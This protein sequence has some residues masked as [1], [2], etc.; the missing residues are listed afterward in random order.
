MKRPSISDQ[1]KSVIASGGKGKEVRSSA[2]RNDDPKAS[3]DDDERDITVRHEA[4]TNEE[5]RIGQEVAAPISKQPE[6]SDELERICENVW[7]LF[8]D[9]LRYVAVDR[10]AADYQETLRVLQHLSTGGGGAANVGD[11]SMA[12][13]SS[14]S[15]ATAATSGSTGSASSNLENAGPP[16]PT[17]AIAAHVLFA[18][19]TT[20]SPHVMDFDE[21]KA[22][23]ESWWTSEGREALQ[24]SA[25]NP[26]S[27]DFDDS[28]SSLASKA[29]YSLIAK[30]LLRLQF[31]GAKRI[32]SFPAHI[33]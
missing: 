30:K 31:R 12:S 25:L 3:S 11:A 2:L 9:N 14:E 26:A 23:G 19:L 21:L 16:S 7:S 17:V 8:G 29:V 10:E 1:S 6:G 32:I 15:Q 5:S 24:K 18:L 13:S 22:R 27:F 28:S 33:G 20:P 4:E